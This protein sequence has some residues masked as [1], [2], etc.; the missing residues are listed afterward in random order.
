V[1][2]VE[3]LTFLARQGRRVHRLAHDTDDERDRILDRD[4]VLVLLLEQT[5]CR[6]VVGPDACRLPTTVVAGWIGVVQLELVV[7]IVP[8][9]Q[10]RYTERTQ[11]YIWLSKRSTVTRGLAYHRIGYIPA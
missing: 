8:S 1:F 9:V 11:T 10:Q 2:D 6:A 3:M 7:G 5:L 4:V